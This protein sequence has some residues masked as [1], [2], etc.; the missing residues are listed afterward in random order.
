MN[1]A[2]LCGAAFA[3]EETTEN[4]APEEQLTQVNAAITQIEGWL[5]SAANNRTSVETELRN[6]TQQI[7]ETSAAIADNQTSITAL[8][9]ELELLA[10]R[11]TELEAARTAQQDL[12]KRAVRASYM[13]GRESYLKLLLNQE[14]PALSARMLRYYSDFNA[15]RLSRIQAFRAT[16]EELTVTASSIADASQALLSRQ[17][18]LDAQVANL[19]DSRAARQSLLKQLDSDIAA[20]SGELEQLTEDRARVEELIKQINDAIASIPP[21]EQL[22]PFSEARGRLPW[23]VNGRAL[24]NFGESYSDGNLHRQGVVLAADAGSPV[25]AVHPGR[26][27]FSDWLRGSGL[28]VVVDHGD[29]Y[30]SLYANN[31]TLI[32]NMGDWVNRDEALATASDNGG[33]DQPGIYFEI[34]RHG[35]A[36]DPALWCES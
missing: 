32:K 5:N 15:E 17:S 1:V 33:L 3:A 23:P 6:T 24:N 11:S 35:E 2:A 10:E 19:N 18:E 22:T 26:V 21:P 4:P 12:V 8:E 25:R 34:R 14:D 27:V 20:H 29:G 31:Q 9:A 36:L 28:L 16:L 13:S 7:A 30:L